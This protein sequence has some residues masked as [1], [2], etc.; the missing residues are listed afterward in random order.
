MKRTAILLSLAALGLS[1]CNPVDLLFPED[2]RLGDEPEEICIGRVRAKLTY[3]QYQEL[4]YS[5]A[6]FVPSYTY[7][8]TLLDLEAIQGL[9][10]KGADETIGTRL[11]QQTANTSAAVERFKLM[12]V[13][14]KGALFLGRQPALYRVRGKAQSAST[15]LA[16]GGKRQMTDTR[17]TDVSWSRYAPG[18]AKKPAASDDPQPQGE[19]LDLTNRGGIR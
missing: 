17:L 12:K 5:S 14:E 10:A 15:I 7:D 6:R 9:V 16:N 11:I 2:K 1:A 19:A 8:I 4:E 18:P 13:D 3:Q